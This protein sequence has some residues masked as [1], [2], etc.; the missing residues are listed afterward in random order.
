MKSIKYLRKLSE[1]YLKNAYGYNPFRDRFD[2]IRKFIPKE[3]PI[4]FDVG[5]NVG[6]T[7]ERFKKDY[8][9]PIIN[10]FEPIPECFEI[11][12]NNNSNFKN[13]FVHNVAIGE[14]EGISKFN[15]TNNF[16]SS[17][18][19]RSTQDNIEFHGNDLDISR[20]IEVQEKRISSFLKQYDII[21]IMKIDVQGYELSVLKSA[22]EYLKN[23]KLISLEIEFIP[24][25]E[26][27]P[28]FSDI[29]IFLR[30]KGFYIY[31]IYGGYWRKNG[32]LEYSDATYLNPIFFK[33]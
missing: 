29:D 8:K 11:L 5:S 2:E 23:V 10:A 27:Q 17:S 1:W 12:K 18:F 6:E 20:C 19:F 25:Y 14:K 31:N 9:N 32:Q 33:Q 15:V 24:L 28:L 22:D 7:V 3:N 4:I 26:N 21:D 16:V 30:S 13:I